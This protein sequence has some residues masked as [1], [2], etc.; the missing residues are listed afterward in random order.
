MRARRLLLPLLLLGAL[1]TLA[2]LPGCRGCSKSG[3]EARGDAGADL[4]TGVPVNLDGKELPPIDRALL[5]RTPPD[6]TEGERRAWKLGTLLG[7]DAAKPGTVV[8]VEDGEGVKTVLATVGEIKD[9]REVVFAV[10]R[11]G[12]ARVAL[13]L[14]AEPFPSF[15][16]RGGNR[17]RGGDPTR[18]R[19]ARKIWLHRSAA[20]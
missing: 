10:N 19:E 4:S 18:I 15:H 1:V 6:F 2:A 9:G 13:I 5:D 8:E 17:G 3:A 14:P 12:E 7:A 11:V 20:P 16:G